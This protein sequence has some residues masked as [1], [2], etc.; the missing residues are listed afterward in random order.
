MPSD[1]FKVIWHNILNE[2]ECIKDE[3]IKKKDLKS[4]GL[5]MGLECP[6][7]FRNLDGIEARFIILDRD[8][9][10]EMLFSHKFWFYKDDGGSLT[11]SKLMCHCTEDNIV[12]KPFSYSYIPA[13]IP[14]AG[15]Y[16]VA[17][18]VWDDIVWADYLDITDTEEKSDGFQT[19]DFDALLDDFIKELE[20]PEEE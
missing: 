7:R 20:L 18:S 11:V 2:E 1:I 3:S 15:H 8:K 16:S 6:E 13:F 17:V 4:L 5:K 19:D 9:D 10:H 14:K 12:D